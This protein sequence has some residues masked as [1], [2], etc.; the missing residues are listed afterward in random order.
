MKITNLSFPIVRTYHLILLI[1]FPLL[2]LN[3]FIFL[4]LQ[5][6]IGSAYGLNLWKE[7]IAIGFLTV[8]FMESISNTK[9]A[10]A[11]LKILLICALLLFSLLVFGDFTESSL[12]TFRSIFTPIVLAIIIGRLMGRGDMEKRLSFLFLV[13]LSFGILVALYGVYQIFSVKTVSDFW[14]FDLLGK[15]GFELEDYNLFRDGS[16]RISSFFTSSLEF[17]F[18]SLSIFLV[19]YSGLLIKS[20]KL[21]KGN[22]RIKA[23]L[24]C[25]ILTLMLIV[26]VESTVRSAQICLIALVFY[27]YLVLKLKTNTTIIVSGITL[28]LILTSATFF[29]ISAG[30][31]GD[32]S[33]L[34]R[35]VQWNTV[36][37]MLASAPW[38]IGLSSIGPGQSYWF[39]SLWLNLLSGYGIF[40]II[41]VSASLWCYIRLVNIYTSI[42]SNQQRF[43]KVFCLAAVVAFPIFFYSAFF[44]AFYN[45]ISFYMLCIIFSVSLNGIKND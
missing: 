38:G 32:L 44:Q 43:K 4:R 22:K 39:D 16:P 33:A 27:A 28:T 40:S 45:S 7:I 37:T 26:I 17:A 25:I 20:P 30:Y 41:F 11:R 18:Y 15:Q 23:V 1:T 31:T 36:L 19:A 12:R 21:N 42:S 3:D 9:V 14:Y 10:S 6:A 5:N 24:L 35:L 13:F 34:G 29:Y 2:L 8:L